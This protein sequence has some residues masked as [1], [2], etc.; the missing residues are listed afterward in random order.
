MLTVNLEEINAPLSGLLE[1]VTQGE[2]VT[3]TKHGVPIARVVPISETDRA[4]VG[5]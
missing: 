5:R 4:D 3:I 1:R 2:Q